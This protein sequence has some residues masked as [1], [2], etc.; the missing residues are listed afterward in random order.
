MFVAY[1]GRLTHTDQPGSSKAL[2][3]ADDGF[4]GCFVSLI[5][6]DP[7]NLALSTTHPCT[8]RIKELLDKLEVKV[9]RVDKG[10]DWDKAIL[11]ISDVADQVCHVHTQPSQAASALP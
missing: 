2:Q 4:H 6:A 10:P 7:A 8:C 1:C 9:V 3:K 11:T 5:L